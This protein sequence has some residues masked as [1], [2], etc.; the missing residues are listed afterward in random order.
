MIDNDNEA[1]TPD[2]IMIGDCTVVLSS[3]EVYA[4]GAR[5]PRRLT[6]KAA[7]VLQVLARNAGSVVTRDE[8]LDE[9]WPDTLPTND[10]L[11]QAIT[12]LR[13]AFSSGA[14]D[15]AG[16]AYIETIAKT[17]YRL[18]V[19]VS[20]EPASLGAGPLPE[21]IAVAETAGREAAPAPRQPAASRSRWRRQLRRHVLLAI[22]LL[23]LASC[24]VMAFL[25]W[26]RPAASPVDAVIEG[27]TRVIGS[28]ERPYRLITASEGF[29]TYPAVSPDGA[30]VAYASESDGHSTLM[31]QAAGNSSPRALLPTPAGYSDRF[32]AWSPDGREIAFARFGPQGSCE[33]LIIGATGG[34]T[35]R[36]TGCEGADMLSFDWT[37]DGRGLLFGSMGGTAASRGI[38][39]LDLQSGRWQDIAY[40]IGSDDFDYAP[41]YSPDGRWIAFVRNPQVGDLWVM[42]AAGGA[43][44]RLTDDAAEIR[45][46]SWLS[47]SRRIVFGRRIDSEARLYRVDVRTRT[48]HDLGLD[49]A[50]S[51]SVA[52]KGNTLAFMHRRPQFGLFKIPLGAAAGPPQ[53]LYPSSGRDGQPMVSPDGRQLAF[54]SDRSGIHALWWA[55]LDQPHTL[56]LIEGLRPEARQPPD[57]SGDS[58]RLLVTGRDESGLA[59]IYEV[60]PEQGHWTRLPVPLGQ[61]LQALYGDDPQRIYLIER[62]GSEDGRMWL[63]LFDR[64]TTP[65]RRLGQ[66]EGVSQAHYDHAGKRLLFTRLAE[67]GL[68]EVDAALSRTSIRHVSVELPTRWRYRTW[69]V[70]AR[71]AV[72]YLHIGSGCATMLSRIEGPAESRCLASTQYGSSNGFSAAPDGQAVYA[73]LPVADGTD[74]G[75]MELPESAPGPLLGVAKWLPLLKKRPS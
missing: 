25:L 72:E 20:G 19:P 66:I 7:G 41:R 28:P 68:W 57:W 10:V 70:T 4:P 54:T 51:P 22:G 1:P 49:D 15:Q 16:M 36:A 37:P 6:P 50:Q 43:A 40:E 21:D 27:G 35:R 61:P 67:G 8:L 58:R 52:R 32:A 12:Q 55:E 59:G 60:V 63:S 47:D 24:T 44:R 5:R 18:L 2:R 30:L 64:S 74:I 71:G 31:L 46:W 53:R 73:A 45:G 39:R 14:D 17:G 11:T 23:L 48:L 75:L 3:R 26:Q 65:W 9:V 29:E 33:V 34:N 38:R 56:R 13:K 69:T 42:P 62:D